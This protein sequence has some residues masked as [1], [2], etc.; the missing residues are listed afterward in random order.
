M[1][2]VKPY[3][4]LETRRQYR[5]QTTTQQKN[6]SAMKEGLV[7][8]T[9]IKDPM[10]L[11]NMYDSLVIPEKSK[12]LGNC[13]EPQNKESSMNK[14]LTP[15]LLTTGGLFA[16]LAGGMALIAASAKQRTKL[17]SWKTLPEV[18]KNIA[19]N[20][21]SHFATYLMIQDPNTKTVLGA[22]GVFVLSAIGLVGKNF[23]DGVKA[24]WV[25]KKE[26]DVQRDLQEK[27]IA[28][29]TQSFSGK[30]QILRNML[31]EKAHE[32]DDVLKKNNM[33]LWESVTFK[34]FLSFGEGAKKSEKENKNSKNTDLKIFASVGAAA[35]GIAGLGFLAFKNVQKTA[36]Y[37]KNYESEMLAQIQN[38]IKDS[39][40]E[41]KDLDYIKKLFTS[42]RVPKTYIEETLAKIKNPI[43]DH[44]GATVNMSAFAQATVKEVEQISQKGA[45]AIAGSPGTKPSYYSHTNDDR[46][47]LY[48][49]I[50]NPQNPLLKILF[51]GMT[52]ITT[53][54]YIGTQA[55]EAI[56]DVQVI[57]ENAKTELNLQ[58]RLVQVEVKNFETK[59]K[60]AIDPLIEEFK[61]QAQEGKDKKELKVRA[62][63]ILY[64]IKNGPPFVYS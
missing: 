11:D 18:P 17:P 62:E 34:K 24:I 37:Y 57:K 33:S 32:L 60:S 3:Q 29:E 36:K 49:M 28:V 56:K 19:I 7:V 53:F 26:A 52:S 59:K 23:V 51:A 5:N 63:N 40:I 64:E 31:S 22:L 47:H 45:E 15:L 54:G 2:T 9:L 43:I 21:E 20:N 1:S 50:V 38:L 6:I 44:S 39:T 41:Y 58:Q 25:R 27:L 14:S 8:N 16:A 48:N 35:L 55:V 4:D 13:E 61:I 42:L 46:A 10:N 30:M 12:C